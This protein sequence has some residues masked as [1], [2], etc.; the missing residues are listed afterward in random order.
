MNARLG[1]ALFGGFSRFTLTTLELLINAQQQPK[2]VVLAAYGPS[3]PDKSDGIEIRK[4]DAPAIASLCLSR[5]I[6]IAYY[7]QDT[8]Q[9]ARILEKLDVALC[10]LAC[11]PKIFPINEF[12]SKLKFVN[13]HPSILPRFRGIDPIFWQLRAGEEQTGFTIHYVDS[14][15]DGGKIIASEP[16]KFPTGARLSEI[17]VCVLRSAV[18]K[19]TELLADNPKRWPARDQDE[20]FASIQRAPCAEDLWVSTEMSA[21]T[22]FNFVRAVRG[23]YRPLMLKREAMNPTEIIDA[24]S[25]SDDTGK[26]DYEL[27]VT[28]TELLEVPFSNGTIWFAIA[29]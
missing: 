14:K 4:R 9:L 11:Y 22:V 1:I 13:I 24:V 8:Y 20:H 29:P 12:P 2:V 16:V 23:K 25:Y 21:K 10:V 27:T 3:H 28:D 6:P 18:G 26:A 7:T 17:Q 19:L 15:I 5:N